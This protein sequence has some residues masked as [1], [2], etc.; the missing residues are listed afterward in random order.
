[1]SRD[2]AVDVSLE[3]R[4]DASDILRGEFLSR[5][6]GPIAKVPA[7]LLE[8]D[9]I[10]GYDRTGSL[11][12]FQLETHDS[13]ELRLCLLLDTD[14]CIDLPIDLAPTRRSAPRA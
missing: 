11:G 14:R 3:P 6:N 7:F 8:G 13:T 4:A 1:M 2:Y 9:K 12:E 5:S 10:A